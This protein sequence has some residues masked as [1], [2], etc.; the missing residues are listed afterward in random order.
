MKRN[1]TI[2]LDEESARWVRV[3]AAREDASVSQFLGNLVARE[4]AREEGYESAMDRFLGR[5]PRI[6]GPVGAHLPTREETHQR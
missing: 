2:V 3:A 5:E 4:R 1:V 6:L